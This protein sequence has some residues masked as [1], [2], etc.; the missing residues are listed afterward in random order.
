VWSPDFYSR[1]GCRDLVFHVREHRTTPL[2]LR[3]DLAALDLELVGF[4]HALA[5]VPAA[6][7]ERWP[8]DEPQVDLERWDQVE[9]DLPRAFAGMYVFWAA[10][11]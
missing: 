6:Y 3:D 11:R 4:Q 9:G 8:D 5:Q 7:R 10:A 1:S 2:R